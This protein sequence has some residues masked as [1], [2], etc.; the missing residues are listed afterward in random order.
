[1]SKQTYYIVQTT[2]IMFVHDA[3]ILDGPAYCECVGA[4][5][6]AHLSLTEA[7]RLW[8]EERMHGDANTPRR[9]PR[10]IKVTVETKTITT[11]H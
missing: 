4:D 3:A 2:P 9:F 6:A 11:N 8:R 1:M 7:R 10:I 5:K